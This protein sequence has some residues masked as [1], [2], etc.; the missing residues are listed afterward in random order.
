MTPF[1]ATFGKKLGLL[2]F[3]H[4]VTQLGC[5]KLGKFRVL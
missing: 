3:P 4:L 1:W 2:L 5:E